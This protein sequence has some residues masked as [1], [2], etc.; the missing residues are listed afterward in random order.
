[1]PVPTTLAG[2]I[3]WNGGMPLPPLESI[4]VEVAK[5][6]LDPC[7]HAKLKPPVNLDDVKQAFIPSLF[8]SLPEGWEMVATHKG[9]P[10]VH[11]RYKGSRLDGSPFEGTI[12][13]VFVCVASSSKEDATALRALYV[14]D[15]PMPREPRPGKFASDPYK[16]PAAWLTLFARGSKEFKTSW[17]ASSTVKARFTLEGEVLGKDLV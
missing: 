10:Q 12:V 8:S 1:M 2:I 9:T 11:L 6:E 4:M 14:R 3:L 7:I 17:K 13:D 15:L 16:V 5:D